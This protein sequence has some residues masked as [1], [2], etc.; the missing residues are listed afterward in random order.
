MCPHDAVSSTCVCSIAFPPYCKSRVTSFEDVYDPLQIYNR[1]GELIW[2]ELPPGLKDILGANMKFVGDDKLLVLS[3]CPKK[4]KELRL[5]SLPNGEIIWSYPVAIVGPPEYFTYGVNVSITDNYIAYCG[6]D[7]EFQGHLYLFSVSDGFLWEREDISLPVSVTLSDDGKY[8][9]VLDSDQK[10]MYLIDTATGE[11]LTV[12]S[13]G[14][15]LKRP[16]FSIQGSE[17][18]FL[19]YHTI[20]LSGGGIPSKT[21]ILRFSDD[22]KTVQEFEKDGLIVPVLSKRFMIQLWP[23]QK[24]IKK[25]VY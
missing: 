2:E 20:V 3:L 17:K 24:G 23:A 21:Y 10:N 9:F 5:V 11:T 8:L 1:Q 19:D 13:L 15:R 4:R 12:Y 25:I 7:L 16:G 14:G 6:Y 18:F 22:W